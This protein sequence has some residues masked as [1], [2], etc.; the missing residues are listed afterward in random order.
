MVD[1]RLFYF[2]LWNTE[3]GLLKIKLNY[4]WHH[5]IRQLNKVSDITKRFPCFT[6]LFQ[7]RRITASTRGL[8]SR[9]PIN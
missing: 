1:A 2:K 7:Q 9:V 5:W 3:P 8:D 4:A 6:K